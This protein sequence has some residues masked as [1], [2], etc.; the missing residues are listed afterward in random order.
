MDVIQKPYGKVLDFRFAHDNSQVY[1]LDYVHNDDGDPVRKI[2][3]YYQNIN[4]LNNDTSIR[5]AQKQFRAV[6]VTQPL[7]PLPKVPLG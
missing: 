5:V 2:N 4:A 7:D 1:V 3:L 6:Q